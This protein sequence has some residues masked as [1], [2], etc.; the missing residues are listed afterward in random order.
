VVAEPGEVTNLLVAM[1]HGSKDAE[2]RLIPLVYGELRRIAAGQLGREAPN[3]SL[4]ATALIHEA[5]IRLTGIREIDWQDRSHFFAVAASLMRRIL[6]EH[7]RASQAGK[8]GGVW[9]PS[10]W[11]KGYYLLPN[12]PLRLSRSTRRSPGLPNSINVN[13]KSSKCGSLLA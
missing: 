8:R 5:Y 4:Q 12:D 1:R 3:H 10:A 7:A 11:T 9:M 2:R 6:V 13:R